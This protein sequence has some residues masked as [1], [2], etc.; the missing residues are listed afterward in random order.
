MRQLTIKRKK[1]FVA[2]LGTMQVYCSTDYF[3][4]EIT[5]QEIPCKKLGDLKNGATAT[6]SIGEGETRIYVVADCI[7]RDWC[8]DFYDLPVGHED[9]YLSGKNILNPARGNPFRFD[10]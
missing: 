5:I 2:C 9:V 10:K 3:T 8:N 6:F 7:S 4:S 1:R